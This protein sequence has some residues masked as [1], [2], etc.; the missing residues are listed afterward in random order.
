MAG[1]SQR[2]CH[3][4]RVLPLTRIGRGFTLIELL[5]VVAIIAILVAV[6][7][8]ALTQAR[9]S[10]R[11]GVCLSNVRRLAQASQSY[12]ADNSGQFPPFRFKYHADG[13]VYVNR[14]GR[15]KPRWQWFL[16]QGVGPVIDP[17]PYVI[18]PGDTFGDSNTRTMTNEY[19]LCPSLTTD[20][21]ARDVRNGPYGYNYQYLGNSRTNADGSYMN[22]PVNESRIE[23]PT[24]TALIGDSRGGDI[25]HGRHAYA[26]DPPKLAVSKGATGFGPNGGSDGPIA[27]SP[28]EPRHA[29]RA[30][31]SFVDGHAA[32]FTL[33]KLGYQLDATG[34]PVPDGPEGSNTL[35]TGTGGDER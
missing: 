2:V 29:G 5:V 25:P 31:V 16:D 12:L 18:N 19:F 23:S 7:L 27:H 15:E 1:L 4:H 33:A 30:N 8:P 32:S 20:L 17:E 28:A 9:E 10:A 26:L 21:Y 24:M 3:S 14:Y 34:S 13:T 6:L 11:T 22:F 35:W